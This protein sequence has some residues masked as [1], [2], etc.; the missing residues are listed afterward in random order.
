MPTKTQKI[1][2]AAICAAAAPS[3]FASAETLMGP[4][5][6]APGDKFVYAFTSTE[7]VQKGDKPP[8]V[9]KTAYTATTTILPAV[10]Y[11]YPPSGGAVTAYPVQTTASWTDSEGAHT[12]KS[13]EYRNFVTIDKVLTYVDY[14]TVNSMVVAEPDNITLHDSTS[15]IYAT[16]LIF[17]KIPE[18][19]G[20]T[21]AEPIAWTGS[22][23]NYFITS[24]GQSNVLSSKFVNKANGSYS[25]TGMNYDVPYALVQNANGTGTN[26]VGPGTAE[27]EWIYGLPEKSSSGDIIPVTVVFDGQ[28][29]LNKVPDWFP[30]GGAAPNPL[31]A[32]SLTDKGMVMVPAGC[33]K[34]AGKKARFIVIT[35][36]QL[37]PVNGYLLNQTDG[38][39][40]VNK[41]GRVCL[42]ETQTRV[43]YDSEVTGDVTSTDT[44]TSMTGFISETVK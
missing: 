14:G 22:T 34:Y 18:V 10:Q 5:P 43:T 27:E 17:D 20:A 16:P 28:Q 32:S 23:D 13:I 31:S 36:R 4:Y 40:I 33:G 6:F 38:F 12:Y 30:G 2:F 19:T 41:I 44:L 26:I 8:N 42:T 3:G 9:T 24:M 7:T 37:A 29:G 35:F 11:T 1:A 25:D 15:K 21:W 39:Y